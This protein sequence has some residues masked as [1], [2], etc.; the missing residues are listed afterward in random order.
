VEENDRM[1][2]HALTHMLSWPDYDVAKLGDLISISADLSRTSSGP[3]GPGQHLDRA[4]R[5]TLIVPHCGTHAR[6]GCSRRQRGR[7]G[8]NDRLAPLRQEVFEMLALVTRLRVT[9]FL[10][11]PLGESGDE[12]WDDEFDYDRH[13]RRIDELRKSSVREICGGPD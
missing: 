3:S 13:E 8:H 5:L 12:L 7:R 10:R 1:R 9:G 6:I 11:R 2:Q 4:T